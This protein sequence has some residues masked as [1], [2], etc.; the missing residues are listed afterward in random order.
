LGWTIF[1][2]SRVNSGCPWRGKEDVAAIQVRMNLW[3]WAGG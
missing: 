2:R 1:T 3:G